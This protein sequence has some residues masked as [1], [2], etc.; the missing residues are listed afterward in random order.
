MSFY[1]CSGCDPL[2]T[3][4]PYDNDSCYR[5]ITTGV[6]APTSSV[7]LVRTSYFAY[8]SYGTKFYN[9]SFS[10]DGTGSL[11][12]QII[13]PL[14][15]GTYTNYLWG[16]PLN[17]STTG[18]TSGPLNRTALW[19]SSATITET[20]LGFSTCLTGVTG[21][22]TYYVGIGADNE[23]RLVLDNVEILNTL[24]PSTSGNTDTFTWWNVYPITLSQGNHTL[25]LYGLDHGSEAGFGM[26]IYDNTLQ[27]LTAATSFSN[28]KIIFSS[29]GYSLADVVQDVNGTY[30]S[31]GYTCPS[32]FTYSTCSGSCIDYEFCYAPSPTPTPTLTQTPTN[33]PTRTQTPTVTPTHTSTPTPT[34]T[35]P[36][37]TVQFRSCEDGKNVFRFRGNTLPTTTGETYY[38]T[39][40]KEFEGCATIVENDGSGLLYES[41][42]VTFTLVTNCGDSLCP[43]TNITSAVL[44]NCNTG[45]VSYF[46]IDADT[47]FVGGTYE[48]NYE[49][50]SFVKFEGPGGPYL[51]SPTY[52]DCNSCFVTRQPTPTPPVTPS[53]TPTISTT[54]SACSYTDFCFNT[55]YSVLS[56]Y[57]GN[58]TSTGNYYNS[59]LIYTGDGIN[60]GVIYHTGEEW[61]LSTVTGGTCLLTGKNTGYSACPDLVSNLFNS[62]LCPTPTP[63]PTNYVDLDFYAYFDVD[64]E[65]IPTPTL[66]VNDL[67][68]EVSSFGVTPTPTPTQTGD[69][70]IGVSFS[71]T[72]F[73]D[74]I[75][76]SQTPTMTLTPTNKIP[77][78]GK[79]SFGI[80]DPIFPCGKVALLINCLNGRQYYVADI[81][82]FNGVALVPGFF[83]KAVINNIPT[84]VEFVLITTNTTNATLNSII[85]IHNSC[86]C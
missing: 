9:N 86:S 3:W 63:T 11:D 32:G 53:V 84:C 55:T 65:P 50:Y 10:S 33:T 60:S 19:Y 8:S 42:G 39:G 31:S 66:T 52:K 23:V 29:S 40:Y 47:A 83:L 85:S 62:G 77:I 7:P 45:A 76:P 64:Y 81:P 36:V 82:T 70:N 48:Y 34:Q 56:G 5:I 16:N 58:Y 30:L 4:I 73:D 22:K 18:A 44:S 1:N 71:I 14:A 72:R 51:G 17:L 35:T 26:E 21:G 12:Y 27:E 28:I 78:Y 24:T 74:T 43:R 54:P 67:G 59:R 68:F 69:F 15:G 46:D 13:T 75:Q 61:C 41:Y 25:E 37:T 38:I 57:S 79:V 20:W 80:V 6:T 2:Y 49:C